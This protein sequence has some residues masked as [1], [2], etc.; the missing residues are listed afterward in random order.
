MHYC[1]SNSKLLR[2][3]SN[4]LSVFRIDEGYSG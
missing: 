2:L 1:E 4:D 3:A